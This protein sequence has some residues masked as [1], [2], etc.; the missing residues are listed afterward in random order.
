MYPQLIHA[1]VILSQLKLLF[2]VTKVR[3]HTD[4]LYL[5]QVSHYCGTRA[6]HQSHV[7][8]AWRYLKKR[9]G[10]LQIFI[11]MQKLRTRYCDKV[12]YV[13]FFLFC[14]ILFR[15][16]IFERCMMQGPLLDFGR[17]PFLFPCAWLYRQGILTPWTRNRSFHR[18][19]YSCTCVML[20][21][22]FFNLY[23]FCL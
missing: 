7:T 8:S 9:S 17:N 16:F 14:T 10:R 12:L 18:V 6:S 11:S 3:L 1:K 15:F 21:A 23:Y 2:L 22:F 13:S 5:V 4:I 19:S 20:T